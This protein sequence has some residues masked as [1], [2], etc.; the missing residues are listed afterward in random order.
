MAA[1]WTPGRPRL[2]KNIPNWAFICASLTS[3]PLAKQLNASSKPTSR[4]TIA[5]DGNTATDA[6]QAARGHRVQRSATLLGFGVP[7]RAAASPHGA[8][9]QLRQLMEEGEITLAAAGARH[10]SRGSCV[11]CGALALVGAPTVV[12]T[13]FAN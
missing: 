8:Q 11:C 13:R 1:V 2:K 4:P 9:Q 6:T 5:A 12:G 3:G 10:G 7:R